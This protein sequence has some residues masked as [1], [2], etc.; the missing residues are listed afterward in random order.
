MMLTLTFVVIFYNIVLSQLGKDTCINR[1]VCVYCV[2]VR[3]SITTN[4]IILNCVFGLPNKV[5]SLD[6]YYLQ[7]LMKIIFLLVVNGGWKA[8]QAVSGPILLM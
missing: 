8:R 7:L 4:I 3:A 5:Y 6:I 1:C 2:C